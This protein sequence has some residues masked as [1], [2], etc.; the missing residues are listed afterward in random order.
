MI[1]DSNREDKQPIP[2]ALYTIEKNSDY[3]KGIL[4][5]A[6]AKIKELTLNAERYTDHKWIKESQIDEFEE[7]INDFK[8]LEGEKLNG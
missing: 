5:I 7:S 6:E 4:M 8:Y 1:C 3:H 2:L